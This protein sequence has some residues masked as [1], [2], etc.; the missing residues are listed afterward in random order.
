MEK[1]SSIDKSNFEKDKSKKINSILSVLGILSTRLKSTNG[2][3]Y[4]E[5]QN[6]ILQLKLARHFQRYDAL[7]V[8]TLYEALVA[9]PN[10]VNKDKGH[11]NQAIEVYKQKKLMQIAEMRKMKTEKTRGI[12]PQEA[13]FETKSHNYYL[14]RLIN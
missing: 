14:A 4:T 8:N 9:S 5:K 6:Y 12:N 1:P 10:F 13:L 7:D 11:L 3:L 2:F